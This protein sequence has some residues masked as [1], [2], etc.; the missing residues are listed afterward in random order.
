MKSLTI[1]AII[2]ILGAGAAFGMDAAFGADASPDRL[3]AKGKAKATV[4]IRLP[5]GGDNPG[6][7]F[8]LGI[9]LGEP[10]G[11]SAKLWFNSA[12]AADAGLAWSFYNQSVAFH[13][14]YLFHVRE[15]LVAGGEDIP[16][17]VGIGGYLRLN[18]STWVDPR[19]R[20]AIPD[21]VEV[22]LRIPL[23]ICYRFRQV[24]LELSLEIAP[25]LELFPATY[26]KLQ[27]G[28]AV[29]YYF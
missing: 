16:P 18:G 24:P 22:G 12:N 27:G 28:I 15:V 26:F 7:A 17:F 6:G 5:E 20:D 9:I 29:R 3:E 2:F 19:G 14:D 25:G 13:A 11:L 1:S 23:G 4:E 8:G 21:P 10:S